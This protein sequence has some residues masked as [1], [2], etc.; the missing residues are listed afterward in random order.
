MTGND[1]LARHLTQ[2]T[3]QSAQALS[4]YLPGVEAQTKN[5][6]DMSIAELEQF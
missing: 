3:A 6:L 5:L 1:E 2:A 4:Q